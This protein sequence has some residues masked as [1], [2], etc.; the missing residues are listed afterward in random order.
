M[1]VFPNAKINIGLN[2]VEKRSDGFHNIE[3]V[4]Y[5]VK[6]CDVLEV[7]TNE[8]GVK[9]DV[10][11]FI[12]GI[13]IEGNSEDNLCVKAYELL[14]KDFNLPAI[15]IYL[16][17]I[18]PTGAGM[19]GGSADATF[20]IRLLNDKYNLGLLHNSLVDYAGKIGSDCS[21]FIDNK[22]AFVEGKGEKLTTI[23]LPQLAGYKIWIIKPD[24]HMSTHEAYAL[25]KPST[26]KKRIPDVIKNEPVEKWKENIVNDFEFAIVSKHP[27][28]KEIKNFFYST[29]AIY[30][31]MTGSGSAVYGLFKE[32]PKN[33]HP[34][35]NVFSWKGDL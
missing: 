30:S 20:L 17:K 5:P 25:L 12:S 2:V 29:G 24:I 34:F 16:H 13:S 19:G 23:E 35:K 27:I 7:I 15:D 31:S 3:S 9:G 21:F 14:V 18:I 33:N 6:V 28:V 8:N 22:P 26:P 1:I 11:I 4:F 32:L 10:R